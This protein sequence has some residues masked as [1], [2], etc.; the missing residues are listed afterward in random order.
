MKSEIHLSNF[1][2][3]K[4]IL[5]GI[6]ICLMMVT[7]VLT[8]MPDTVKAA[9]V[10]NKTFYIW[11]NYPVDIAFLGNNDDT[12]K[13]VYPD[14]WNG[15]GIGT[16]SLS[17][18]DTFKDKDGN[19]KKGY[20][21][22]MTDVNVSDYTPYCRI[23]AKSNNGYIPTSISIISDDG[24]TGANKTANAVHNLQ[25]ISDKP[26][27]RFF[28]IGYE[29]TA[30]ELQVNY[31]PV[32]YTINYDTNGG[33]GSFPSQTKVHDRTDFRLHSASPSK[34][35][36]KF[37]GWKDSDGS[38]HSAGANYSK[39]KNDTM[40][41]QWSPITYT[42]SFNGNKPSAASNSVSGSMSAMTC[43]YD[44]AKSLTGNG[45]SLTGWSFNGWN[46]KA[47]GSGVSYPDYA[48]VKN[49]S[50]TQGANITLYAQWKPNVYEV[51]LNNGGVASVSGTRKIYLKYDTCWSESLSGSP[52][53][54][55]VIPPQRIGYKFSGY[56]TEKNGRGTKFINGTGTSTRVSIVAGKNATSS[57]ITL[58][59]YWTPA[60]YTINLDKNGGTGGTSA[61]YEKYNVNWYKENAATTV[62]NKITPPTKTNYTFGGYYRTSVTKEEIRQGILPVGK[63][64]DSAGNILVG[65]T[66]FITNTT[67]YAYWIPNEY[68]ISL[69]SETI[70]DGSKPTSLGTQTIYEQYGIQYTEGI[71]KQD[72]SKGEATSPYSYNG[73]W[74]Y[75]IA[76]ADGDYKFTSNG[77]T[78]NKYLKAGTVVKVYARG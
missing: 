33:S 71:K 20:K 76:P 2:L 53:I 45:Y 12:G 74:Q 61:M 70:P 63:I 5:I 32:N 8:S 50:S 37:S 72:A 16:I 55:S 13:T 9:V 24:K 43:T 75:F 66:Q 7:S 42:V 69:N 1:N 41:A 21:V 44:Q 46:T 15:H 27:I 6:T 29:F 36:Y 57:D 60:V 51:T 68:I 4:K 10:K 49:L 58:Y 30:T 65:S 39:N 19:D 17:S 18:Y 25:D 26:N 62:I 54:S 59:A 78:T 3:I 23:I 28:Y 14:G 35:G 56:Y 22:T 31:T 64:T 73:Q 38:T 34:V 77:K 48:S 11:S 67:L 47:N 40:T 52:S